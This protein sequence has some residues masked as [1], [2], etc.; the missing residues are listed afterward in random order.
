M[1][2]KIFEIS[3]KGLRVSCIY[4]HN[5]TVNPY[6]LYLHMMKRHEKG[7]Y[8][9][10]KKQIAKYSDIQSVLYHV[11]TLSLNLPHN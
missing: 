1:K 11:Y 7:Y 2:H 3:W 8:T 9:D 10:S 6:R 4:F 5:D